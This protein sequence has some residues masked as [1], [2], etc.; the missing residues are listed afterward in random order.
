MAELQFKNSVLL[1]DKLIAFGFKQVGEEYEYTTD[2][3][4]GL[5]IMQVKISKNHFLK[6]KI[7]DSTTKEEYTL[8]QNPNATGKFVGNVRKEYDLIL[9]ANKLFHRVI[10]CRLY[11]IARDYFFYSHN[12]HQHLY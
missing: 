3:L 6:T 2:I 8:H 10:S 5:L 7:I 12:S 4:D 1:K 9:K 11:Q